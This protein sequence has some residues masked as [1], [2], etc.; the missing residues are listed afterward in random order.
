M[1]PASHVAKDF[2]LQEWAAMIKE[3]KARPKG[4]TIEQWCKNYGITRSLYYY[5]MKLVRE[6]FLQASQQII[7]VQTELTHFTPTPDIVQL[8]LAL[9]K[10]SVSGLT[11]EVGKISIQVEEETSLL[12]LESVL[13]VICN[14]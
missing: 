1:K 14:A 10:S 6:A 11:I 13:K 7:P 12:L 3:S 2:R 9:D 5:R 8:P 4:I